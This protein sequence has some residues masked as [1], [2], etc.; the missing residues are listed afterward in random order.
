[1]TLGAALGEP[2]QVRA[3]AAADVE[4]PLAAVAVEVDQ[5]RQMVQLLEVILIEIGEELARARLDAG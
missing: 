2:D 1:M 4:H 5:P 3:R